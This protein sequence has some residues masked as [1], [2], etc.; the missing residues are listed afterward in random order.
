[1]TISDKG[2]TGCF[3]NYEFFVRF[4]GR[5]FCECHDFV[6]SHRVWYHVMFRNLVRGLN[7][8]VAKRDVGDDGGNTASEINSLRS[9]MEIM[10]ENV[11]HLVT[12]QQVGKQNSFTLM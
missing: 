6:E 4:L 2:G 3:S 1:M 10:M 8:G 12:K 11:N 5:K 9:T 7:G